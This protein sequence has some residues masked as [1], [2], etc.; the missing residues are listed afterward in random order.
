M[1]WLHLLPVLIENVNEVVTPVFSSSLMLRFMLKALNALW[2]AGAY[3]AKMVEEMGR[4]PLVAAYF[5]L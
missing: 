2:Q 1:R 4:V 3:A 5:I